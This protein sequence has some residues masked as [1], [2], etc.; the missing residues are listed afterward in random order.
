MNPIFYKPENAWAC[1]PFPFFKDG[2]Y[3]I[4]YMLDWRQKG[5]DGQSVPSD[6]RTARMYLIT[7][8][9]LLH[10]TEHGEMV[11]CGGQDQADTY[12]G[13][14]TVAQALGRYHM[15]YTGYSPRRAAEGKQAMSVLHAVSDDLLRWEKVP[16]DTFTSPGGL[17]DPQD[18]KDPFFFWN[19]QAGEFWMLVCARL[20][21]GPARRRG[22]TAL[23]TS[24]DLTHWQARPEPFYAPGLFNDH[25]CGDLFRMGDWWYF[26]FS[27]YSERVTTRY[28]MARS[29]AG[30]WL[31]P[32]VDTCDGRGLYAAKTAGDGDTRYLFG[33]LSTRQA[34]KDY[35]PWEFGGTM[36]IHELGQ[37]PDG[38]LAFRAP[39]PVVRA[40][41]A[42][43]PCTIRPG[44][45]RSQI[46]PQAVALD[47]AGSL[48]CADAGPLPASCRIEATIVYQPG[49]HGCG[50]A[51]RTSDD[52]E[53]GY[54]IRLEPAQQRLVL[55]AWPRPNDQPFMIGLE[56]PLPLEP[57]TPIRL[58]VLV[59]D[60]ICVVYVNDET[61][62]TARLYDLPAGHWGPFVQQGHARLSD[63]R[64]AQRS[65]RP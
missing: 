54:Y 43:R 10:F 35:Q 18:W 42:E 22:C 24:S 57:D 52:F 31:T 15:F 65:T 55:D 13:T 64:L 40:F 38:T 61:A 8:E 58:T 16:T 11:P 51:L 12:L 47:A 3:Y 50:L 46:S 53:S 62:M 41:D 56:R 1:D 39:G 20:K 5:P 34:S 6:G 63:L 29:P 25:D 19:D 17:F 44:L 48:A 37:R 59:E 4:Y 9:D 60:T 27:E 23:C 30:P 21:T 49:T 36:V 14:G 2:T 26:L 32:A 28:R 45:G 7:T 33:W